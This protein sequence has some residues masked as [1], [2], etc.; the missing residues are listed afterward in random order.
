MSFHLPKGIPPYRGLQISL[1][2]G[3]VIPKMARTLMASGYEIGSTDSR[4]K[5]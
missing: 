3:Y 5:Q 2:S 1:I 4:V